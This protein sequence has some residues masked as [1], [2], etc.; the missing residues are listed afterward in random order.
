[1]GRGVPPPG[2]AAAANRAA[3]DAAARVR[4]LEARSTELTNAVGRA[5]QRLQ[6]LLDEARAA[7]GERAARRAALEQ[8]T[9]AVE[10]ATGRVRGLEAR[11]TELSGT[12]AGT[13]RQLAQLRES[14]GTAEA[15]LADR[16]VGLERAQAELLHL[17]AA[18][19]QASKAVRGL[20]GRSAE[21]GNAL[22][23]AEQRLAE[24][25]QQ[26]AAEEQRLQAL[27]G[28]AGQAQR[29]L[30]ERQQAIAAAE[31]R[32][33][34]LGREIGTAEG[35][36]AARRAALEE[37][38]N[39]ARAHEAQATQLT[40]AAEAARQ[41][42]AQLQRQEQALRDQLESQREE[43]ADLRAQVARERAGLAVGENPATLI[44]PSTS[45]VALSGASDTSPRVPTQG[46]TYP[47]LRRHLAERDRPVAEL[48][49][50]VEPLGRTHGADAGATPL[51]QVPHAINMAPGSLEM[52][53]PETG[54]VEPATEPATPARTAAAAPGTA[55]ASGAVIDRA[56][57]QTAS[58][59]AAASPHPTPSVAP[60]ESM[61]AALPFPPNVRVGAP[62][63]SSAGATDRSGATP[64]AVTRRDVAPDNGLP[65]RDVDPALPATP[66]PRSALFETLIARGDAMVAQRN[67]SA[68]RLL[69]ERAATAGD[70][71]AAA[72][73]ARTYD[74]ASL[75]E[76]GAHGIVADAS[77]AL[78][79][80]RKAASLGD[81]AA[82]ARIEALTHPDR[83]AQGQP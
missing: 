6:V 47:G 10:E 2:E 29:S 66:S 76:I 65:A 79:W 53:T 56:P 30:A 44:P 19:D 16:R 15:A 41:S 24:L 18:R 31:Q 7:E 75:A 51:A 17:G 58:E 64:A 57:V 27:R 55:S 69:Y 49:Q 83:A 37:A 34:A 39:R 78:A 35:E 4:G 43:L 1:V 70:G 80:Y 60:Q 11:S 13:E 82:R 8:A 5:E 48:Q 71:R 22:R 9:T 42:L 40:Q 12:V 14:I 38:G 68:A 21:A 59:R 67:I 25:G 23:A 20:E 72:A 32:L 50:R 52:G 62:D 33:Q 36:T 26:A 54:W 45:D 77:L 73:L 63:P 3:E 81:D 28:E 46:V 61:A 74:P